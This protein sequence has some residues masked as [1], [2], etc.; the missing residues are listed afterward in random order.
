MLYS[1]PVHEVVEY[2]NWIYFFHSW[3]FS[4]RFAHVAQIHDCPSCRN[5]WVTSFP[6]EKRKKAEEAARLY[7]DARF[8]LMRLGENGITVEGLAEIFWANSEGDD[9]VFHL[10][11][12]GTGMEAD[13]FRFPLLR[14]QRPSGHE[15][16]C[17]CLADFV[18]P[19]SSGQW[20]RVGVF[21][22]TT[23]AGRME[24]EACDVYYG[25]I[26]QTLCDRLSEAGAEK[27]HESVRKRQWGYAPDERLDIAGLHAER[28]QGIRPAVGYPCMPDQSSAFL[29]DRLAGLG[30]IGIRLTETGAMSPSASTCG[31]M[32]A[33]PRA[34]YFPVGR[35]SEEQ[36][37][38]Y[39]RRRGM[40]G[41]EMRK[42]LA[43][44]L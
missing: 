41:E 5:A 26:V 2:I 39:A 31:L 13:D 30:R 35:I 24:A 1:Y 15:E 10:A 17:L 25:M 28:F 44:N 18:R 27:M 29:I 42:F 7:D 21:A 33:H 12:G 40:E 36:M 4:P 32:L 23:H 8:M 38:D 19:S 16:A 37:H 20:D 22:T 9:L 3:G 34:H 11:S 14:Q 6:E 43:G